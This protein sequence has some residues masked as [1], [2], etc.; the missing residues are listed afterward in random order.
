VG[1]GL[2]IF[3]SNHSSI[4]T[5]EQLKAAV[6]KGDKWKG[7][8]VSTT[9]TG[10]TFIFSLSANPVENDFGFITNHVILGQDVT[11]FRETEKKLKN[12]VEEK[13]V[14]L[15]ELHHRVKNNLAIISGLMQLQA[16]SEPDENVQSK[17]FSSVGRVQTM[18]SMHELLY[19]SGSFSKVEF[20]KNVKKIVSTTSKVYY[21]IGKDIKVKLD[22]ESVKLNINQAHPCSLILNEVITNAYKHAFKGREQKAGKIY[23]Q[24]Y[25]QKNHVFISIV[26]NGIGLPSDLDVD[27]DNETQYLGTTL[28]KTLVSQLNGSYQY[29]SDCFG[30]TFTLNFK[31]EDVKGSASAGFTRS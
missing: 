17:L 2:E 22:V 18:A 27:T 30:T 15:S 29:T 6:T 16:F 14:L 31:K 7:E 3:M 25:T 10:Q 12:A 21:D 4:S 19:E 8:L 20:G 1:R 11:P 23:I 5:F 28:L 26:D 24:L 13:S 9:K